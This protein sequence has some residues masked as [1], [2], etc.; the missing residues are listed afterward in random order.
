MQRLAVSI[1]TLAA[2]PAPQGR[3]ALARSLPDSCR[4]SRP[5]RPLFL[6]SALALTLALGCTREREPAAVTSRTPAPLDTAGAGTIVGTVRFAGPA[7]QPVV[8]D[9]TADPTCAALHPGGLHVDQVEVADGRLAGVFVY[10]K[11]GLGE[12]PFAVPSEPVVIDQRGCAYVPHVV[13]VRAGQPIEFVNSDD[14][15]HNVHGTPR[16]SAA[17]NFGMGVRG[18]RRTLTIAN[19]EVMVTISCNVHSWMHAYVGVVDHPY[20]AV[21]DASGAYRFAGVPPGTFVIAAWH[22]RLGTQEETVRVAGSG[23]AGADFTFS[24]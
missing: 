14:T 11:H 2:P 6:V 21:T 7:P 22:E 18:A 23:L 20:F 19:P 15:L 17:W 24:P 4:Q 8:V 1:R 10:I 9:I 12:R 16:E 13:G 5:Q 3:P